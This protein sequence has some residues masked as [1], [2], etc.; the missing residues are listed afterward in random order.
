MMKTAL[1]LLIAVMTLTNLA[2]A[3][4]YTDAIDQFRT[5]PTAQPFFKNAYGYAIFPSVGKGGAIVGGAFGEG[6]VYRGGAYVGKV[7]LTQLSIGFQLGGQTFSELI[8]F[9][10]KDAFDRFTKGDF[11][12][13]AQASAV[14]IAVGTGAQAGTSGA[15]ANAGN[16]QSKA[17]Y[18]GGFGVFSMQ[19]GGLMYEASLSGQKF[20]YHPKK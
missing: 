18:V 12:F 4:E 3:D 20:T 7:S 2:W 5:A 17:V 19:K 11:S 6:R 13:D 15:S 1:V 8:F 9:E 10:N 14:A 16:M